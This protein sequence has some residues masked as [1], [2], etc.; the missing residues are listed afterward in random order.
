[1]NEFVIG[2][3]QSLIKK[4]VKSIWHSILMRARIVDTN[5]LFNWPS[6]ALSV[7]RDGRN[8]RPFCRVTHAGSMTDFFI[9]FPTCM[10]I[11]WER[12]E[13][14]FLLSSITLAIVFCETAN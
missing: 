12:Q 13:V 5:K 8:A 1:M 6:S 3:N 4:L 9:G 7:V 14:D 2:R 10:C 11:L